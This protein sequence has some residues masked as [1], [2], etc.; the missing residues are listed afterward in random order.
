MKKI[1]KITIAMLCCFAVCYL[2]TAFLAW[3][4]YPAKRDEGM[5]LVCV[6]IF[7]CFSFLLTALITED[8]I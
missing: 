7:C 2:L 3:D 4:W 1:L 5:R 8:I 6:T